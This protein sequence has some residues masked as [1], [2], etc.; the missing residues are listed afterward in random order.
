MNMKEIKEQCME[1]VA[2]MKEKDH[3]YHTAWVEVGRTA[4]NVWA[5]VFGYLEDEPEYA[6]H[7]VDGV[8]YKLNGKVAF[9]SK[10]CIM[11]E[12]EWDWKQPW[13]AEGDCFTETT[14][15]GEADVD[16]LINTWLDHVK[17]MIEEF[18]GQF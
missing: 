18:D 12:Y 16:W 15:G 17:G 9:Q 5:I 3:V 8:A 11:Q 14:V 6:D 4:Q 10:N 1:H 7:V 2:F 13:N